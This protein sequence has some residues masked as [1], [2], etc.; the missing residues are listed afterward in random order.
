[1]SHDRGLRLQNTLARYL[2]D[3]WP[4]ARSAGA[5]RPGT[6]VTGTP[7]IVWE[8]KTA[9]QFRPLEWVRQARA[10]ASGA[11]HVTVYWPVGSGGKSVNDVL[12]IVPLGELVMLLASRREGEEP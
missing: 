12:A 8:N 4:D 7:G 6:D 1:M 9:R 5:G 11:F 10:H 3:F 2:Q